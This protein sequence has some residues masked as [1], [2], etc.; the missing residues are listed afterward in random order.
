MVVFILHINLQFEL[1]IRAIFL[2]SSVKKESTT[3]KI[4]IYLNFQKLCNILFMLD[5]PFYPDTERIIFVVN[6]RFYTEEGN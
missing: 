4:L 5:L 3:S 1:T 6:P 2:Q